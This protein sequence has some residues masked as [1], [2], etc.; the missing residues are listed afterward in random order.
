MSASRGSSRSSPT[1]E[2]RGDKR[3]A[4][5]LP[6]PAG[7]DQQRRL[8]PAARHGHHLD[9]GRV[10]GAAGADPPGGRGAR[11]QRRRAHPVP[12]NVARREVGN[13]DLRQQRSRDA[14]QGG[15]RHRQRG[16]ALRLRGRGRVG[17]S[18]VGHGTD[19][20]LYGD[21]WRPCSQP[22]SDPGGRS[23]CRPRATI[24]STQGGRKANWMPASSIV[25]GCSSS[26]RRAPSSRPT[27]GRNRTRAR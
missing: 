27:F 17:R 19:G 21:G 5:S 2:L 23:P 26:A 14:R 10:P 9:V 7:H 18:H 8:V 15:D 11:R 13:A 22:R 16:A 3:R 25:V 20:Q 1:A 4:E 24:G 12:T 6:R